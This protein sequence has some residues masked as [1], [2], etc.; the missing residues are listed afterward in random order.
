M[1]NSICRF[2]YKISVLSFIGMAI[3]ASE[4]AQAFSGPGD[5]V[6]KVTVGFQAWFGATGDGSPQNDWWHWSANESEIFSP[7]NEQDADSWPDMTDYTVTYQTGF[8]NLGSGQPATVFSSYD[9]STIN[10]QVSWMQ[11][12][13]IDTIALQR[14]NP[15]PE[16]NRDGEAAKTNAAAIT[17][18][19]KWFVMYD[20][21]GWTTADGD[22]QTDWTTKMSTYASSSAYAH[23]NGQPVVAVW[24]ATSTLSESQLLD[25]VT[26]LRGQGLY[27]ILGVERAWTAN[28]A[29]LPVYNAANM[30]Q[31]WMI[32]SIG[33][34][35]DADSN[36][37]NYEIPD[38][39]Y[40]AA[41]G[42]DYQDVVIPGDLHLHQRVHGNL[43]WE[44]FYNAVRLPAQG[45]YISMYDEY[46]EG[47]MIAKTPDTSAGIPVGSA[48]IPLNEDGTYCTTDYYLRL[49]GAGGRM[50][51]G[52][53]PLSVVRPTY[54]GGAQRLLPGSTVALKAVANGDYVCGSPLLAN[55]TTVGQQ[56]SYQ[57]VDAGNGNIALLSLA[58][59]EY[60]EAGNGGANN[61]TADQ[62]T[63][64]SAETFTEVDAEG[65]YIG[66][67]AMANDKYVT[68]GSS[69]LI[70]NSTTVGTAQSF[71][72]VAGTSSPVPEGPYGGTPA[73]IPG[74]VMAENYDTGGQGVGYNVTSVNG[75]DNS[76]RSDGVDLETATAPATGND[77]GWT[78]TG[79]WF[80]YTVNVAT[81]GK[82]TVTFELA[83]PSAVTDAFHLSN[84]SGTNLSGSVNIPATGGW[85]TWTTVT[86]TVTLPAGQQVLTLDEDNGG[87]NIDD[88][89]F[90][91]ATPAEGPYGGTP[92]AIPGTVKA[93]NYDTGGQ[94]VAYNVTSTNGTDNAFRS[95]GVDLETATAPATG[96]DLGWTASGQWFKY[97]VSVTTAGSYT[98]SFLV[99]GDVA[100][101][102]AF[103]L[104][105]AAGTNLTGSV[106]VPSTGGWQ[107][108]TTVTATVTLPAGTQTLTL[109]EDNGGWNIDTA[110][111]A[112]A[113]APYGGTPAAVP[114]TVNAENY[115]TG[116]QGIA[117]NVTS[118][119]GTDNAYRSDGV[120]LETATA[121]ATGNDLGW[122]A[123][124]QWFKYTV[125]VATAGT[126]TVSFLV[127]GDVSVTD[128][129]H[130]SNSTGTNLTGSVAVPSTGGW[131]AWT[132]VT[133]TVTLP[134]GTQTLTLDE[135]NSG[136]NI[137]TTTFALTSASNSSTPQALP[138]TVNAE[139]NDTGGRGVSHNGTR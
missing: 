25:I 81:A 42:L 139:S 15:V 100:V 29:M 97:T 26:W 12:N 60:V 118:T 19:R 38:E 137:D 52:L 110:S 116:G 31:P 70:A 84:S 132:T 77:L 125:N 117:Y 76:Y 115:D 51:K 56:D 27:V 1:L 55:C 83:A 101:T 67:L 106:A 102:D 128:A 126:Y 72:V 136:W 21:T 75:T 7:S 4:P 14:F 88:T 11:T 50:L 10:A 120:D 89:T 35:S 71:T 46:G 94:G 112:L 2:I 133:K 69:P 96:N 48:Y 61:L 49:T 9:Q 92:S 114:G 82:Y 123:T 3:Y 13:G 121:P 129:F 45:I 17:Y 37:T 6:G 98:V 24:L 119:N 47:N 54:T 103:H 5:V 63:V 58:N 16:P 111:F 28:T 57:V 107:A 68:A 113:N 23:Q 36:Y 86:T 79:Q 41:H 64:G 53:M 108:W 122:T 65:G 74:T 104:S 59:N 33:N 80:R 62:T 32:G 20:I 8:P 43:M 73:A 130:L 39:A 18:G 127:A 78:A 34:I 40:C 138:G 135:D 99:A 90:A 105:N 109:D 124:G 22:L 30:I 91:L 44:M 134:A 95:D 85:Q 93:E 66:L 131:Q 87:W